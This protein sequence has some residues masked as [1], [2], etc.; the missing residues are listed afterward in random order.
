MSLVLEA[1]GHRLVIE[2][3]DSLEDDGYEA[4]GG[5]DAKPYWAFLWASAHALARAILEGP[6]F[7][8]FRSVS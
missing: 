1:G 6:D 5:G 2:R 4:R 3:P 8:K 7:G